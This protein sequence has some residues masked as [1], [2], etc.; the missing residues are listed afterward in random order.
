MGQSYTGCLNKGGPFD[1]RGLCCRKFLGF[2]LTS[3]NTRYRPGASGRQIIGLLDDFPIATKGPERI[4]IGGFGWTRWNTKYRRGPSSRQIIGLWDYW[5]VATRD[6]R[7]TEFGALTGQAGAQG[8]LWVLHPGRLLYYWL[9]QLWGQ[10][11]SQP[12]P[13]WACCH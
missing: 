4:E 7:C 10:I 5:S 9:V 11:P 3:W 12:K 8:I 6:L 13:M 2:G 1:F